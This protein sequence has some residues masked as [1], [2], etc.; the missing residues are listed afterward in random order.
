MTPMLDHQNERSITGWWG[1]QDMIDGHRRGEDQEEIKGA[2]Y[3]DLHLILRDLIVLR[4]IVKKL[5]D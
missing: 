3:M 2:E 1:M 4:Y 5:C